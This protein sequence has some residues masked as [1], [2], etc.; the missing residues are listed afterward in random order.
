MHSHEPSVAAPRPV[1]SR[2]LVATAA[3]LSL[4]AVL[5]SLPAAGHTAAAAGPVVSTATTTLGQT[6]VTASGHTLYLFQKDKNGKSSCTGMCA[7]FWPPLIASAKPRAGAGVKASLLGTTKRADGRLQVT[8]NHH[9]LYTFAK[10][11]KRG[12]TA[13][14]GVSAFGA[15][16]FAV[17]PTGAAL[18]KSAASSGSGGY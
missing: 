18:Q 15:K 11:T 12:Q 5:L 7:T 6:V 10:D 13:G 17:S 8:Y 14:E 2:R 9:P 3:A 1:P 4:L 16:W